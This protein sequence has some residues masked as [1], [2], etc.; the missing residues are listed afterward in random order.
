MKPQLAASV[1]AWLL[2]PLELYASSPRELEQKPIPNAYEVVKSAERF[3]IGGV[4]Y[5][6]TRAKPDLALRQ[7]LKEPDA[8]ARCRKLLTEATPAGQFYAL[9]GLHLLDDAAFRTALP[10]YRD[11][12][13]SIPS[14]YGCIVMQTPARVLARKIEKGELK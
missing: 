10:R 1:I 8:P 11:S 5:A 2:L 6:G 14:M 7:L 9:L 3:S 4:G 12:K 13:E